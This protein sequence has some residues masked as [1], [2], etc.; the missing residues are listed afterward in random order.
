MASMASWKVLERCGYFQAR[1]PHRRCVSSLVISFRQAVVNVSY[2]CVCT[3]RK[4][5]AQDV[6]MFHRNII[7]CDASAKIRLKRC[8]VVCILYTFSIYFYSLYITVIL[9]RVLKPSTF[10][11]CLSKTTIWYE[12]NAGNSA[13]PETKFVVRIFSNSCVYSRTNHHDTVEHR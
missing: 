2:T 13:C 10:G 4:T 1:E 12:K 8:M 7:R 3:Y 6:T 5:R 11:F 9:Y